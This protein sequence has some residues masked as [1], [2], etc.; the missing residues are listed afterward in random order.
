MNPN[1]S[2]DLYIRYKESDSSIRDKPVL[3]Y[4]ISVVLGFIAFVICVTLYC[5]WKKCWLFNETMKE[6]EGSPG[7]SASF[8]NKK[9]PALQFSTINLTQNSNMT[10]AICFEQFQG[11]STVRML[12]CNHL[13]H[14]L[15]I[16]EWFLTSK[17]CCLCKRDCSLEESNVLLTF[18]N[19]TS[20]EVQDNNQSLVTIPDDIAY[21]DHSKIII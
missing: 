15:C 10:C 18:E 11:N 5:K 1:S 21:K 19:N 4:S 3:L 2:L 8:I 13:F 16:E 20:C 6:Q 12:H 14:T 17:T 7:L 9:Y